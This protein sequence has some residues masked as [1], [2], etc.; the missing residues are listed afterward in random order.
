VSLIGLLL[1]YAALTDLWH[2]YGPREI[3]IGT[4]LGKPEWRI[5]AVSF[6]TLLVFH[7]AW[8]VAAVRGLLRSRTP[9]GG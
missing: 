6:W 8:L 2:L 1:L 3:W 4:G 9:G 5:A 7:L